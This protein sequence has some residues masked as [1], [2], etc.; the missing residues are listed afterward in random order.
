MRILII[1][2]EPD[3]LSVLTQAIRAEYAAAKRIRGVL[4]YDDLINNAQARVYLA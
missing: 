4:D 1:E 3:L 2:D